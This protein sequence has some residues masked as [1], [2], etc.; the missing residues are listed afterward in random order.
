MKCWQHLTG[1]PYNP[2][3]NLP[4]SSFWE[5]QIIASR[6]D[7]HWQQRS[8]DQHSKPQGEDPSSFLSCDLLQN[9]LQEVSWHPVGF[10]PFVFWELRDI[11]GFE[12]HALKSKWFQTNQ[13]YDMR[14]RDIYYINFIF[15][16][17][18][19]WVV[20]TKLAIVTWLWAEFTGNMYGAQAGVSDYVAILCMFKCV[21]IS[22]SLSEW[23]S[24]HRHT[25][26]CVCGSEWMCL[27]MPPCHVHAFL[28][29]F[30]S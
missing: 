21:W 3:A 5:L 16:A 20:I 27:C 17:T 13:K 4:D 10:T 24:E 6:S 2:G 29:N 26:V 22:K 1:N 8:I 19:L 12:Q 25:C 30:H 14:W 15:K 28:H 9:R 11:H 23:M 7:R 18:L